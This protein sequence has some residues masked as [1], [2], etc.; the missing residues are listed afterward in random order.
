MIT[1]DAPSAA[2]FAGLHRRV[3]T[4]QAAHI[5]DS[6]THFVCHYSDDKL[7]GLLWF[8]GT[9]QSWWTVGITVAKEVRREGV[10]MQLREAMIAWC[11]EHTKGKGQIIGFY[12][13]YKTPFWENM[14]NTTTYK[15]MA[16][17][18]REIDGN[19]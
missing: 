19:V 15:N 10:G 2:D 18:M 14:L 16:V 3:T 13:R 11:E 17:G 1:H 7:T 9:G 8:V 6:G 4:D 12:D 5:I